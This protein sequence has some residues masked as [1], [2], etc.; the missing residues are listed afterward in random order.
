MVSTSTRASNMFHKVPIYNKVSK[1]LI[2]N[3]SGEL[4]I[5]TNGYGGCVSNQVLRHLIQ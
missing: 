5:N 2:R 1:I 3:A 4:Y